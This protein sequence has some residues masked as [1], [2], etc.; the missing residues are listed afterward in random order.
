M[1]ALTFRQ[2]DLERAVR[3]CR[4]AGLTVEAVEIAVDGSIRVLT[5]RPAPGVPVNDDENWIDHAGQAQDH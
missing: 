1:G 3:G 5:R 4:A 2:T